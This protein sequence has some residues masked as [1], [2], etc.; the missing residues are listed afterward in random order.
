MYLKYAP[1]SRLGFG[2]GPG[3]NN[4]K[5]VIDTGPPIMHIPIRLIPFYF[6]LQASR[7]C[8]GLEIACL[9][10][11]GRYPCRHHHH[12]HHRGFQIDI[13]YNLAC[14]LACAG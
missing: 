8:S 2:L 12:H 6:F 9:G 10:I 1:R 4:A 7:R 13:Q 14:L 11:L 3:E 5:K